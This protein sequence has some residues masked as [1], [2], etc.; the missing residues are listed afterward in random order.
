MPK[1]TSASTA[2]W[3]ECRCSMGSSIKSTDSESREDFLAITTESALQH[4]GRFQCLQSAF[5]FTIA[6]YPH[7]GLGCDGNER[8]DPSVQTAGLAP[9][10]R[11]HT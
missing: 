1:A 3:N 7:N 4:H 9:S 6:S 5:A 11:L 10:V 8:H 2:C